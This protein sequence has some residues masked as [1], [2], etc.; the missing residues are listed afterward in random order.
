MCSLVQRMHSANTVSCR[1]SLVQ[2]TIA[3]SN[4]K[5]RTFKNWNE[6]NF[7]FTC[8]MRCIGTL[9]MHSGNLCH[10][11]AC[12]AFHNIFVQSAKAGVNR[13]QN[14]TV[15]LNF[16]SCDAF[17]PF[18]VLFPNYVHAINWIDCKIS[19]PDCIS[20]YRTM[21]LLDPRGVKAQL[22]AIQIPTLSFNASE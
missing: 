9:W 1:F 11:F 4:C 2:L 12:K 22:Y 17:A 20:W 19:C 14:S 5:Q 13:R 18:S 3:H 6:M 16:D 8:W 15:W 7:I 10:L 21:E